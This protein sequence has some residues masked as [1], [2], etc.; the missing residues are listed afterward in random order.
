VGLAI[1]PRGDPLGHEVRE[2]LEQG[3][4]GHAVLMLQLLTGFILVPFTSRNGH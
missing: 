4:D 3:V 2:L 1:Q